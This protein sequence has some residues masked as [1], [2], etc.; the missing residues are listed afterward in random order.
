MGFGGGIVVS[1]E[2]SGGLESHERF[3]VGGGMADCRQCVWRG[4]SAQRGDGGGADGNGRAGGGRYKMFD[5]LSLRCV[6][7]GG[8]RKDPRATDG[9]GGDRI[10]GAGE[11]FH[12]SGQDG[13]IVQAACGFEGADLYG[14]IWIVKTARDG[15]CGGG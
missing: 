3:A 6:A 7:G 14:E 2:C 12:K 10:A 11:P 1:L 8:G 15:E 9:G 5:A 4:D 13:G